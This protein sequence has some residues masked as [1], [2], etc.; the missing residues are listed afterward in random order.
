MGSTLN[1]DEAGEPNESD[2][3]LVIPSL[4]E[5]IEQIAELHPLPAV[6]TSILRLTEHDRF[7]AHELASAITADQALTAKLLRL[8]NSAYY[9]FPRTIGTVRDAVVLLG[10]RTV[11]STTLASCV[12]GTLSGTNHLNYEEFWHFSVSTGMLGEMLARTE[13]AHQDTAF[14]AGVLH[15]IGLLAMDQQRP[16][17]LGAALAYGSKTGMSRHEAQR[18]VLGYTDADLGG[19]LAEAWS[20]PPELVDAIRDHA[21]SLDTLPDPR[22]L[23]AFVLRARLLVR[24]HG[25]ADGI[26]HPERMELPQEWTAPPLSVTLKRSGGMEGVL[27]KVEA[28]LESTVR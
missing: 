21:M 23:T 19:G 6:A 1:P 5:L 18:A 22:S 14:T 8:A 24:S 10:F 11:R 15:N 28:F 7:S 16:E 2:A 4:D 17:L 13:G 20:F 3:D 9:G 12:I 27:D 25:V 26:D